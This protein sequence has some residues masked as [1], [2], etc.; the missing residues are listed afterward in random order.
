MVA[1]LKALGRNQKVQDFLII[2]SFKFAPI[3]N[4]PEELPIP[5]FPKN[6]VV[7][8]RWAE[9]RFGILWKKITDGGK[10][11]RFMFFTGICE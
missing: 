9:D 8:M 10:V 1:F 7:K 3:W 2:I 6:I 11:T 5:L 4:M